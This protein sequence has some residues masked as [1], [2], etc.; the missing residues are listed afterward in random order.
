MKKYCILYANRLLVSMVLLLISYISIAQVPDFSVNNNSQCLVGN[1]FV[2]TNKSSDSA[3]AFLWNFSDGTTS[4]EV[5]PVKIYKTSGN[6]S[7]QLMATYNNI[8]YF[9]NKTIEVNPEP[10][11]GFNYIAATNTGNSYTFL[12]TSSINSGFITNSW[13]IMEVYYRIV[14]GKRPHVI[15]N[16]FKTQTMFIK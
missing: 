7:V 11:C 6:Y 16:Y 2:F 4:T 15:L 12:S 5:N 3:S 13:K 8:N 9:I 10:V 1:N 14:P